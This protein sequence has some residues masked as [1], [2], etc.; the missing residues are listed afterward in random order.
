M[1]DPSCHPRALS[2]R[3][4]LRGGGAGLACA[5][6]SPPRAMAAPTPLHRLKVGAVELTIA[7]D[8]HLVLPTSFLAPDPPE[9]ERRAIL[10]A[11]GQVR[12]TDQSPTNCTLIRAASEFILIDGLGVLDTAGPTRGHIPRELAGGDG[13][14]IGG[15]ALPHP[16]ISFRHPEWRPQA[17]HV[18]DRAIVTRRR[19][20][21]RLATDKTKFLGFHLPYP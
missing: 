12:E 4:L 5:A 7:T 9:A 18:P 1:A 11:S 19:L 14:V 6:I 10:A 15:D 2:R 21:D 20:L 13:R 17:D 3:D 16:I 8:G